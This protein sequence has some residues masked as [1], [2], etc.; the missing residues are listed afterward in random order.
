MKK[1]LLLITFLF[2]IISYGQSIFDNPITDTNP[3]TDNP[4][5][6]G[7]NVNANITVSG[8]GRGSGITGSSAT[9]RYNANNWS[10]TTLDTNDYFEFTL[11][12]N[13]GYQINFSN[14]VYTSQISSGAS[15]HSFRSSLDSFATDI[16]SPNATG[17]TISLVAATYQNITTSI[18]FRFYTYGVSAA[19]RTFSIND[20]TF[21]GTVTASGITSAQTGNWSSTSTWVGGVVP[22]SADNAI[23]ANGHVVTMDTTSGGINTRNSGTTTTVVKYTQC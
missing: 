13:S 9:N 1:L 11:T 4:Y 8:I 15:N 12:P 6:A 23:I 16:G 3:S 19:S 21:N 2:S 20:F 17:T 14:F 18:T 10:T 5:I 22:T 7:Q